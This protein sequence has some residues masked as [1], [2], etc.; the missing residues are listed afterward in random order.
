[1]HE[2]NMPARHQ[3]DR[4]PCFS[5]VSIGQTLLTLQGE[6]Y[7]FRRGDIT[8]AGLSEEEYVSRRH[9]LDPLPVSFTKLN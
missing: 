6:P 5:S 8:L 9:F 1:M 7:N 3:R 4:K 2:Q